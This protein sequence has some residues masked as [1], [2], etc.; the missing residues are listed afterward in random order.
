MHTSP[1]HDSETDGN[2]SVEQGKI[3]PACGSMPATFDGQIRPPTERNREKPVDCILWLLGFSHISWNMI[4]TD[5]T[6]PHAI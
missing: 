6:S 2:N 1:N 3:A 5:S 4:L